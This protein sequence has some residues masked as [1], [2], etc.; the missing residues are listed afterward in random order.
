MAD[1]HKVI[2]EGVVAGLLGATA[3]AVWFLIVDSIAGQPLATPV[4]LGNA[5]F[6]V[7]GPGMDGQFVHLVVYTIFH[8]VAFI[9]VGILA[10]YVVHRAE[11]EP[12]ILAVFLIFFVAFELAFYAF[13]ALLG[14]TILM[15]QMAWYQIG[16][17]NLIAAALMGGYLWRRHPLLKAEFAAALDGRET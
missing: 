11:T 15:P 14:Q 12:T 3:I 4:A 1:R 10:T 8:Y 7:L 6:S 9:A 2:N 17:A 13:I 5:L 16:I